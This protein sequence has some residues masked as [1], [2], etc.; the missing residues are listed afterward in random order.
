MLELISGLQVYISGNALVILDRADHLLQTIYHEEVQ[1]LDS[2]TIDED[3]GKIAAC[4]ADLVF[5][6]K[7]SGQDEGVLKWSLQTS[8][9]I[10]FTGEAIQTLSWGTSEE[11]LVGSSSLRLFQ[12]EHSDKIIWEKAL[13]SPVQFA[14]FS[15]DADLIACTARYDRLVKIWRRLSFGSDEVQFD[16]SYLSHP[17]LVTGF[18]W[19]DTQ[20]KKEEQQHGLFTICADQKV[21]VWA[22]MNP[23][24]MQ[25]LQLW[26]VIDMQDS[27]QPRYLQPESTT[28][29]RF[30]FFMPA[31]E[32]RSTV[33]HALKGADLGSQP[34]LEHLL[35]ISG[36]NPEICVVMDGKGHM[37]AWGLQNL[38]K[39]EKAATDVFNIALVES[40]DIFLLQED[41]QGQPFAR[42]VNFAS[43]EQASKYCV[44][45]HR[46]QAGITW[47]EGG[48]D[49]FFDP[50]PRES[51]L[52]PKA[53]WTG[54][55]GSIKKIVR[56]M[57]GRAIFSRT[58]DN[59]GSIWKQT[60]RADGQVLAQYSR[61]DARDHIHRT[62]VLAGGRFVVNLHH[63]SIS[64]WD[65]V[66]QKADRLAFCKYKLDG[67][68]LCLLQLPTP[69]EMPFKRY[70]V[71]ITSELKGIVWE[72]TLP[73]TV[74]VN[75]D[76]AH[77][78]SSLVQYCTFNLGSNESLKYVLPIDPA[79]SVPT[80]N[81]FLDVFAKD[82][83]LAYTETGIIT[84]WTAR[85]D[86]ESR[87]INWLAT[88]NVS[89][90]IENPALASGSSIRKIALVNSSRDGLTIWDSRSGQ[91]EYEKQFDRSETISDLDWTSTP[92]DQSILAIGFP[93]RVMILAQIR[94]DY[95]DK[96][97]AWAPIR[98]IYIRELTPHPIGDSTWLGNGN[99]VIGAGNQLFMYDKIIGPSD[100]L[101]N[102]YSISVHRHAQLDL[103]DLTS[104][105]NGPL[106]IYHPQFLSQC[107]LTGKHGLVQRV[108]L[109]LQEALKFYSDGEDLDSKLALTSEKFFLTEDEKTSSNQDDYFGNGV[110]QNEEQ[111]YSLSEGIAESL[112][113]NLTKKSVPY[114]SSR[115]QI[116]LADLVECV[117]TAEKHRRSMDDNG[118]RYLL[119]FRQHMLRKTQ[120]P[121][122]V[123]GV[124]WREFAWA[125]YSNSQDILVD[126]VS[127]HFSNR[128][129][130]ENAKESG[131]F[132]WM[133]DITTLRAQFEVIARNEYTKT[134]EKNPVDCSLYYLALKKKNV[135]VGL[136]RMATWHREQ[137]GTR[138]LLAEN[139]TDTRWKT[140]ALKN[141]YALMGKRRFEYAASFFLLADH[142]QDAVSV[143]ANQMGDLQL[144]IAVAR[145]YDGDD[146]TILTNLLEEHVLPR[147][148]TD[149]NRWMATWAFWMLGRRDMAVRALIVRLID[150][151]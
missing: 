146:S 50:K 59:E 139:F 25:V 137:S 90:G 74:S 86:I 147:A 6:Y 8:L 29:D 1:L 110:G 120:A 106:P 27:I 151:V 97:A 57:G 48:V 21:R 40:F 80:V 44:L 112:N 18:Q 149:G 2:V 85:L 43:E 77:N 128:M 145:V 68:P 61:L 134:D 78:T 46:L 54:H 95:L 109:S 111:P 24:G 124:S 58:N 100:D 65:T 35:D 31:R 96:G 87:S 17:Q 53:L 73:S 117:A 69:K 138:R 103:F 42:I 135:L 55:E 64:L 140:A 13:P 45:V 121:K 93:H 72:I 142:L 47:L 36:Q 81:G 20:E 15:P 114:L 141:A 23:H 37:C 98:E 30:V 63:E 123:D 130:W 115:E 122:R 127:R 26:A 88:A 76:A 91:L 19:R 7:P 150:A 32:F 56:T 11:L 99:L 144:A 119:F 3:S 94:Y 84:T 82:V 75:G 143:C 126:L 132:M 62:A 60:T 33:R 71:I 4:S 108:L 38:G 83:A 70:L 101:V 113:G 22:A 49:E 136:W 131:M 116:H 52:H 105:L 125:Y 129:L 102:E 79:G 14:T 10:D 39:R 107:I 41:I 89:T 92:D 66:A 104:I 51:R 133:T 148:A 28:D 12:T 16:F 5:I 9:R 67:K 118:L 34:I